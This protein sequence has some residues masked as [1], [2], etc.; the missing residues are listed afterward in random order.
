MEVSTHRACPGSRGASG[1]LAGGGAARPTP[2]GDTPV[3][4]PPPAQVRPGLLPGDARAPRH[5]LQLG[6]RRAALW[7]RGL[8]QEVR[9]RRDA[10]VAAGVY[11]AMAA[12]A[13]RAHDR[14]IGLDL[15]EVAVDQSQH[16]APGGGESRPSGS[17]VAMTRQWSDTRSNQLGSLTPP[18]PRKA[19]PAL[20]KT[21]WRHA[22]RWE[23]A[24]R[25]RRRVAALGSS[26]SGPGDARPGGQCPL[27]T[28]H[29]WTARS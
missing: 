7:Q 28:R 9:E 20:P 4:L 18:L 23:C 11:S 1:C 27:S 17:I 25:S 3:W 15:S 14:A 12:E 26:S 22:S 16:K 19:W 13:T 8:G 10:W 21:V 6:G 29:P 5:R 2:G 24:G